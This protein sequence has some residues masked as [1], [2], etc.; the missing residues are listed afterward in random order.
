MKQPIQPRSHNT[1]LSKS[2]PQIKLA[3]IGHVIKIFT[4]LFCSLAGLRRLIKISVNHITGNLTEYCFIQ[5][6]HT[7]NERISSVMQNLA[8]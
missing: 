6:T 8:W 5:R 3:T 1:V 2:E 4:K 7:N